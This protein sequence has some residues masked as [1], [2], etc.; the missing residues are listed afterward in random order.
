LGGT[1]REGGENK[2]K[3]RGGR[4]GDP[5]PN[6]LEGTIFG[7]RGVGAKDRKQRG[8][9]TP[10]MGRGGWARRGAVGWSV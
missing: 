4:F 9:R 3:N 10:T 5:P 8:G 6:R 2:T 7:G 1:R